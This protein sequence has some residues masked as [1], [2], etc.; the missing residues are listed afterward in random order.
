MDLSHHFNHEQQT[1]AVA[2]SR[3]NLDK[4]QTIIFQ[5]SWI[6]KAWKPWKKDLLF[7]GA[8]TKDMGWILGCCLI[9]SWV[10]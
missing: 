2:F 5:T 1:I 7:V 10:M 6:P 4:H 3:V 8:W 9:V